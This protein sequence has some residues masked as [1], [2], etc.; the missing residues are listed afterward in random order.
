MGTSG[1]RTEVQR[2]T[3]PGLQGPRNH[4]HTAQ[5]AAK[6]KRK[7]IFKGLKLVLDVRV[8]LRSQLSQDGL[9][10]GSPPGVSCRLP[11]ASL[12]G[13]FS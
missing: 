7:T 9:R 4:F 2:Y 8:G 10:N 12:N 5:L 11:R 1:A 3:R 13:T 6:N